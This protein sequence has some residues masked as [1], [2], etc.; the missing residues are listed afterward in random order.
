MT[1]QFF[2]ITAAA[3]ALSSISCS[4]EIGDTNGMLDGGKATSMRLS[5]TFPRAETRATG[6]PNATDN[7]AQ[8]NTVDVFIYTG[9]GNFSSHHP[10]TFA[11][12]TQGA[13][14]STADVYEYA[15][16]T[17]IPTT[18]G[19]KNVFV[20][21]N[22]PSRIV[23]GVKNQGMNT[24]A[25]AVQTMSRSELAGASNFAMFSTKAVSRVFSEDDTNPANNVT[26]ECER[27]VAKVTVETSA[28][29]DTDALPGTVDNLMFAINN[30]NTKLFLLQ[31]DAPYHKDPNWASGSWVSSDFDPAV[32][33]HYA[34]I[35]RRA[36]ISNPTIDQYTPRY[37]AENT[38]EAKLK[39]EI[40][41]VTV[42]ATFIPNK[43]VEGTTG[44]F[45]Q[46]SNHGVTNAKTFYAV[47]PSL[48]E[49]TSFFFESTTANAFAAEKGGFV[50][51]YT[52]GYCYWDIFLNKNPLNPVNRWDVL[53][54]DFYKCVITKISGLGRD[55][56][57]VPDPEVTPDV[58]T[59]ITVKI[60]ILFWH[61]P[62]ISNYILE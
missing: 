60:E 2:L 25:T 21:I 59:N 10:L 29:L 30:F 43:V 55:T 47:T 26:V 27:M 62:I 32:N 58:D 54:N 14:T 51:T 53:R 44:N 4:N 24:L 5:L 9:S 52:D 18:T 28:N 15:V 11:D 12:F 61:T 37:A 34:T 48:L 23:N 36:Q 22:L 33:S 39:K 41:R 57:D 8:V 17:K 16:S 19:A 20:G 1:K 35:L 45:T 31:G 49:G 3:L 46:N 56:P 13:S 6:D 7:E 42:R 50:V 38:S 40:T